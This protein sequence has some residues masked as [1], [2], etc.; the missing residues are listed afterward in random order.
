MAIA[1]YTDLQNSVASWLN[2]S[3]LAALIP[4][5]ITLAEAK[6]NGDLENVRSMESKTTLSTTNN[7]ATVTLPSDMLEM[8]RLV[9]V[10][11]YDTVLK[12][13]SPDELAADYADNQTGRPVVFTVSGSTI[14][15]APIPDGVYS[16]ELTYFQKVPAL[17][18]SNTT[19]WLL[20]AW[21]NAYLYG[22]LCAA[23]PYLMNDARLP[24]FQQMYQDAVDG[25][26]AIDWYSGSTMRVK[27]R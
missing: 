14:E 11:S 21:P 12:Y 27:A 9:V 24:V 26:N 16:L 2:R 18:A 3:D 22:A 19:N 6:L 10:D 1:N 8:K 7:V 25:I 13:L 5:F 4:D 17:S 20:S 15:L 23:Q